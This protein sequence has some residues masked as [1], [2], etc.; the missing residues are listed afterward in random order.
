MELGKR[1]WKPL[2]KILDLIK[3]IHSSQEEVKMSTLIEVW[4]TYPILMDVFEGFKTSL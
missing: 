3:N 2:E 4:K 1:N